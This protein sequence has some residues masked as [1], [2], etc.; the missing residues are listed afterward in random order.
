MKKLMVAIAVSAVLLSGCSLKHN[1]GIVKVNDRII[2]QAEFDKSFE[3]SVDKTFLKSFGGSKNLLKSEDNPIYGIF[4]DKV[5]NELIVKSLLESEIDKRGI[6]ATDEDIQNE[7]KSIID[8]VGSKEELNSMLKQR[9]ISNAQFTEDLKTQI[10]IKKLVDSIEKINISD[11]ET[12]NYYNSHKAEFKHEEQVRAS[13]ILVSADTLQ[14]IQ[15]IKKKNPDINPTDLNAK[16][17]EKMAAQKAKAE[18]ILAEV[19]QNPDN[20]AKIAKSKSDDKVSAQRGGELGFF[21]KEAMVPE[22]AQA[23]FAMKPD[24]ISENVVKTQY[25]YHIIKVTDRMEAGVTPY[26][27]VKDDLKYYLETQKQIEV[28]KKLT[29]GL[30]KTAKIEYLNDEYNPNKVIKKQETEK[31]EAEK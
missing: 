11:G 20:F 12:K 29:D 18:A 8:R 19:K 30:M 22:F 10:K 1:E 21:P 14:I 3:A 25:G 17:E 26:D 13:H 16:V 28:L 24:T 15:E 23:A 7:L 4:R 5:I 6:K 9:G 31:K 27:K 2:T